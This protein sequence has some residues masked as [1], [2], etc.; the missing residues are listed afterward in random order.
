MEW[1]NQPRCVR[2][3]Y[4]GAILGTL[5]GSIAAVT[6]AVS[7]V[8]V[9]QLVK[10][11]TQDI[12]SRNLLMRQ[13]GQSILFIGLWSTLYQTARCVADESNLEEP[14]STLT[15]FATSVAPF[16][17]LRVFRRQVPW[18]IGMTILDVYHHHN[19][20]VKNQ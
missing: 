5:M 10:V 14:T 11:F 12:T 19:S 16:L 17:P 9:N 2:K 3:A 13:S 6:N 18:V 8:G 20:Q 1:E 4:A 7:T 15:A